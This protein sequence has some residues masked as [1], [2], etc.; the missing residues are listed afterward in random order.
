MEEKLREE[1]HINWKRTVSHWNDK[2]VE[3]MELKN[4]ALELYKINEFILI[5]SALTEK[6]KK[7][8]YSNM[9]DYCEQEIE[10]RVVEH[11]SVIR[12]RPEL[13]VITGKSPIKIDR[14]D[15]YKLRSQSESP[16][17]KFFSEV[18]RTTFLRETEIQKAS[19]PKFM[20]GIFGKKFTKKERMFDENSYESKTPPES[21]YSETSASP[22]AS[23]M[24]IDRSNFSPKLNASK[25]P[26]W[27]RLFLHDVI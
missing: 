1:Y 19:K 20:S 22:D 16:R 2:G 17:K 3:K 7:G 21:I 23:E 5:T 24:E 11:H 9:Q 14:G 18:P 15:P 10:Q 4:R 26:F 12:K 6:R 25:K 27:K 8:L 13:S